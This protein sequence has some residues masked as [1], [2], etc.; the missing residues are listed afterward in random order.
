MTHL[1]NEYR[2]IGGNQTGILPG[3]FIT[4]PEFPGEPYIRAMTANMPSYHKIVID[5]LMDMQ[6][7]LC[8]YGLNHEEALIKLIAESIERY[9]ALIAM[10]MFE[11]EIHYATYAELSRSEIPCLPLEYLA[12][13]EPSQQLRMHEMIPRFSPDPPTPDDV[14]AWIRCPSL[15]SPGEEIWIPTQLFFLGFRPNAEQGD[16]IFSPSFSTGTAAHLS[17]SRALEN[18]LIE[19]VQIDA[20]ML[21]WYTDTPAPRVVVDDDYF[22]RYFARVGLGPNSHY[23]ILPVYVT[24][25]ELPLPNFL[26]YLIRR[27]EKLPYISSGIQA[28]PDPRYALFRGTQ[29]SIAILSM[30]IYGA[31][32]VPEEFFFTDMDSDFADLDTN[33]YYYAN[34]KDASV[35]QS[36]INSR[37]DGQIDLA[38]I[39]PMVDGDT[40]TLGALL[41]S[42]AKISEWAT[43]LDITPSE[44][45]DTN[46]RVVRTLIPEL[47]S[48]SLPGVPPRRHPRL[49]QYGG[50]THDRPHPLP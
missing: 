14:I 25:P 17:T 2:K 47:C 30:G 24:R 13:F 39:R 48:L 45:H 41:G 15:V 3:T 4:T 16:K 35:K 34:P 7:H 12:F 1:V 6:Y 42:I 28:D 20:F 21:N 36:T 38:G 26:V 29:E 9:A 23:D 22:D 27:D 11:D 10:R 32:H 46:W 19:A 43:Y 44:L 31:T 37:I 5:P 8:G 49:M 40:E 33:V 18:A 50:V